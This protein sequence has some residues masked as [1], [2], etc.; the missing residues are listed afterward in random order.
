MARKSR[1]ISYAQA[2][3]KAARKESAG[4]APSSVKA[5]IGKH[6]TLVFFSKSLSLSL[7][8]SSSILEA[9]TITGLLSNPKQ[10]ETYYTQYIESKKLV[11]QL[12]DSVSVL[13]AQIQKNTSVPGD[14]VDYVVVKNDSPWGIV[15]KLYG[16][17]S[18]WEKVAQTIAEDNGIWDDARKKWKE[19]HPGQVIR[20][21]K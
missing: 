3:K 11:D 13:N 4:Q 17:R 7:A 2:A 16:S 1:Y 6:L 10:Q 19:I 8:P 12:K 5:E 21:K 15:Y 14:Y 18:D 20:I 9:T